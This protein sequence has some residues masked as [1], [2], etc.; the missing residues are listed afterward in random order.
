MDGSQPNYPADRHPSESYDDILNRDTRPVPA[1]M[2]QGP[3]PDLG[4]GGIPVSRY[5]SPEYFQKEVDHIWPRVWQMACREEEIHDIGDYHIYEIV[6]K[7]LIVVRTAPDE[8]KAF[9]NSCLHRGRKLVTL[10]GCKNEFRCPYHGF[11]WNSD[12]SFK[13]NPIAWDFPQWEGQDMSLPQAKV[14]TWGG[15]VFIN[16]DLEAAPLS[17]FIGPLAEDFAGYDY[18]GRYKAVHVSKV[19]RCN[20]KV[21]AEAFMESH[22]SITTHPQILPFLADANSQYDLLSDYVS[23]QFSASGVPSPWVARETAPA[24][25]ALMKARARCPKASAPGRSPPS[26]R[27]SRSPPRMA[28]TIRSV[29]TRRWATPCFITSGRI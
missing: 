23:R 12:G 29:R 2:R 25:G 9:Y 17:A 28:S 5:F 27:A 8:I 18:A 6:G 22:H 4:G 1:F 16:M 11:T 3:A 15:F 14:D 13:E 21:L 7:S 24:A 20:W 19:V 26:R 10:N